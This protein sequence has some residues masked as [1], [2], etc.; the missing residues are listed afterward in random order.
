MKEIKEFWVHKITS[1][2]GVTTILT[3]SS[4]LEKYCDDDWRMLKK[5]EG[6]WI[7]MKVAVPDGYEAIE[8]RDIEIMIRVES[9]IEYLDDLLV[10]D[11]CGR[12]AL[13]IDGELV[14][15]KECMYG[16]RMDVSKTEG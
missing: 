9:G 11:E 1:E 13:D 5:I 12:P 8:V 4:F 2:N 7:P 16:P 3:N 14:V 10:L 6:G 15:L